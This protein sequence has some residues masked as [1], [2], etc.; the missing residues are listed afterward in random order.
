M[1]IL[2]RY[3][4]VLSLISFVILYINSDGEM[5]SNIFLGFMLIFIAVSFIMVILSSIHMFYSKAKVLL[6]LLI[7]IVSIASC[8][9]IY[10]PFLFYVI[11]HLKYWM[12]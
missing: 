3:I 12:G 10:V 8:I 7:L 11:N 6:D 2:I 1:K 5:V 4:T 9:F